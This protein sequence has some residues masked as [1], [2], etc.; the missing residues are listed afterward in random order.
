MDNRIANDMISSGMIPSGEKKKEDLSRTQYGSAPSPSK[1][2]DA[3][4]S[5]YEHHQK[6]KD[7]N[8]IPHEGEQLDELSKTTTANYLYHAKVDKNYV[9]GGKMGKYAKARDKGIERA[10]KK[11]GK[12]TSD[13]VN[14]VA[15]Y[16]TRS[17]RDDSSKSEYPRKFKVKEEIEEGV[18]V[19]DTVVNHFLNEGYQREDIIKA[20]S[21]VHLTEEQL[22]QEDFGISALI[23]GTA[24][25]LAKGA[26]VAGKVAAVG[27][28]AAAA[29]AKGGMA[30]AKGVGTATKGIVSAA[31]PVASAATKGLSQ[32]GKTVADVGSKGVKAGS[33]GV[34]AATDVAKK[35][36]KAAGDVGQQVKKVATTA[37]D[38]V[39]QKIQNI[40]QG[41]KPQSK[42]L[43]LDLGNKNLNKPSPTTQTTQTTQTPQQKT[44]KQKVTD[45][46]KR[47]A[48]EKGEE[49]L[50]KDRP[51]Q[52]TNKTGVAHAGQTNI[53]ASA[54]LFDIVKG[55]LL[56]EG[57]SE[58]EIKDIM[59]TLT[60]DEILNEMGDYPAGKGANYRETPKVPEKKKLGGRTDGTAGSYVEKP[61]ST[62]PTMEE[63]HPTVAKNDA[64]NKANAMKRA[65]ERE[66]PQNVRDA[67]KRQT[68]AGG[69]KD[70][71]ENKYTTQD[72]KTIIDYHKNRESM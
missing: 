22:L 57:L 30:A 70:K 51:L 55:R 72:K 3:Y 29:A 54:D 26:A 15:D 44:V 21:T 6:D 11:L 7:G 18:D 9:H 59:L 12:K 1:L 23:A 61:K 38:N 49:E 27:G 52:K 2:M 56:D 42:Q 13:R 34:K 5:M 14:Y 20:M 10:E 28:K 62:K 68:T 58:E 36:V 40:A 16:D 4:K 19:F 67:Q 24:A 48:R 47:K 35:S 43:Q 53:A 63:L 37:K 71:G 45:Y 33:K 25:A 46:A 41:T 64:I 50:F 65:K 32:V 69:P 66:V 31:K 8:T 39:G 60:A 17:M